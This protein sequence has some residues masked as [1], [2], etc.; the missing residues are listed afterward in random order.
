MFKAALAMLGGWK[1]YAAAFAAG[2][3]LAGWAGWKVQ[4]WHLRAQH[5]TVL[6][7]QAQAVVESVQAARKIE[8][9]RTAVLEKERDHAIEQNEAL[10]ADLA[11][12]A[13]VSE[14]L[15]RELGT[16]RARHG[17]SDTATANG[18]SSEQGTDTIGLL[19]ELYARMDEDGREV[20]RFA[21][22]LRI[23]GYGCER[24][25]DG[26]VNSK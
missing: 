18:S 4:G 14:R 7:Q 11:A 23:A 16:V 19:A 6:E 25:H 2:A 1:G 24:I 22:Q 10:A 12:G 17:S 26:L 5:A 9:R 20:T 3:A 15:R 13:A 21:D 8:Q